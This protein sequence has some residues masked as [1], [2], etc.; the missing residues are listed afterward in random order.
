MAVLFF[1]MEYVGYFGQPV[2]G[3]VTPAPRHT[4]P[5]PRSVLQSDFLSPINVLLFS[6]PL[7]TES[8][9]LFP[10]VERPLP[11]DSRGRSFHSRGSVRR[12]PGGSFSL[13]NGPKAG[14]KLEHNTEQQLPEAHSILLSLSCWSWLHRLHVPKVV[15]IN[16]E[17]G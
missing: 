5:P 10:V 4:P 13:P 2:R 6:R 12:R 8:P 15:Y 9:A 17:W 7:V 3:A 1:Y 11:G 16:Q 14:V